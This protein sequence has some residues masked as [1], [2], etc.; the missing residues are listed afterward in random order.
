[1]NLQRQISRNKMEN[2]IGKKIEVLV[3]NKSFDGKYFIGRT[4]Q[5]VPEIDGLVYIKN[6]NENILNKFVM[7]K[8]IDVKDYDLICEII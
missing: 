6:C 7:C 1:M 8:V 5:D 4:K 2:K 3:E